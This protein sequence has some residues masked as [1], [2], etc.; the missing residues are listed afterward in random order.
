METPYPKYFAKYYDKIYHSLRDGIDHEYFMNLIKECDGKVLEVGTGTGRFF[1]EALNAGSDIYG[2]DISPA[3]IDVLKTKIPADQHYRVSLQNLKNFKFDQKFKLIVAPFRTFMHLISV[4]DQ[5][6]ALQNVWE[7]LEPGGSFVFDAF[8]PNL[9]I[10]LN[11]IDKV[12]DFEQEVEPGLIVRRIVSSRSNLIDQITHVT[13]TFEFDDGKKV[14]TETWETDLR[15][16][17][18]WELEHL[19]ALSSFRIWNILGDFNGY[20]L[21]R[22][23]KDFIVCCEK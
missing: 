20:P 21:Q 10:L 23:S 11:G 17:F 3:M 5:F 16:F 8:V 7:H 12:K 6:D 14:Y 1:S 22:D 13:F 9:S 15:L 19:M 4:K 18:R 2:I